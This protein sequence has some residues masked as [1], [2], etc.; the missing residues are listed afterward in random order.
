MC[1]VFVLQKKKQQTTF[2]LGANWVCLR[3]RVASPL[4]LLPRCG[5]WQEAGEPACRRATG[6]VR[7]SGS[8]LRARQDAGG[9]CGC[10]LRVMGVSAASGV[11]QRAGVVS[12]PR[13]GHWDAGHGA[14]QGQR[15]PRVMYQGVLGWRE[16]VCLSVC[17]LQGEAVRW[18]RWGRGFGAVE[19]SSTAPA[20]V[21]WK[22][23]EPSSPVSSI[24]G[25]RASPQPPSCPP[26]GLCVR[27]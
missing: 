22:E 1:R 18:E 6:W 2:H 17:L 11:A 20:F 16:S 21:A 23:P 12:W 10:R 27:A 7:E 24:A 14:E 8:V 19:V 4:C 3:A 26:E 13:A 5:G 15:F 25:S 9:S